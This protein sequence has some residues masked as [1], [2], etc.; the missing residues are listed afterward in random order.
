[1]ILGWFGDVDLEV[2]ERA[3]R[4]DRVPILRRISGGGAVVIGPGCLNYSFVFSLDRRPEL[5]DVDR[6]YHLILG[7]VADA[8]GV[9]GVRR[10]GVSDL[11]IGG[12]KIGGS[13]QRRGRR[14]LLHHG[15]LLYAFNVNAM[16]RYLKVPTRQPAYRANRSHA[17]F[18]TNAP[19]EPYLV[20]TTLTASLAA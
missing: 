2:D 6:S 7:W 15:T 14:A 11:A 13:A 16:D 3:C 5:R 1:M 10:A 18:V 12:R 9:A 20:S 19:V 17:G 8:I 4:A